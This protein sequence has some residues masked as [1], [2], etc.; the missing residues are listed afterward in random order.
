MFVIWLVDAD[1][2]KRLEKVHS[3]SWGW[4][5]CFICVFVVYYD[6]IACIFGRLISS[7]LCLWMFVHWNFCFGPLI[8]S[9]KRKKN[10][11]FLL[12]SCCCCCCYFQSVGGFVW[13]WFYGLCLW[14]FLDQIRLIWITW[15]DCKIAYCCW[16]VW[17][18]HVYNDYT[19]LSFWMEKNKGVFGREELPIYRLKRVLLAVVW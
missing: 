19:S 16:L 13:K 14:G 5:G 6:C 4:L 7:P 17:W 18:L 8:L 1:C 2:G 12:E 11:G 9:C 10:L 15:S 3:S